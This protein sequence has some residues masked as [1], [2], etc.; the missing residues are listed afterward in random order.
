VREIWFD[1]RYRNYFI[2]LM[3]TNMQSSNNFKYRP[4]IAHSIERCSRKDKCSFH[5]PL[6]RTAL[7]LRAVQLGRCASVPQSLG[8]CG[9]WVLGSASWRVHCY[10]GT[11]SL[12]SAA[13]A[14]AGCS[15]R[16]SLFADHGQRAANELHCTIEHRYDR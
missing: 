14:T 5:A 4:Q 11:T 12:V 8:G 10:V 13:S 2:R 7:Y 3:C 1:S 6:Q 15:E 9:C 16:G